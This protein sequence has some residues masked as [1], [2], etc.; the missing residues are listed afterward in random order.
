MQMFV[1]VTCSGKILPS[2][3]IS[4]QISLYF[5]NLGVESMSSFPS[6]II[7]VLLLCT[8]FPQMIVDNF[9]ILITLIYSLS[10]E[11]QE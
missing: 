10:A 8:P 6:Y 1:L 2:F 3:G 5:I 7:Q 4:F 11:T 9:N